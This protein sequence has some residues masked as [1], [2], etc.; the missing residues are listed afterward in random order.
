[1]VLTLPEK[2]TFVHSEFMFVVFVTNFMQ[3]VMYRY[4]FDLHAGNFAQIIY[5]V[6]SAHLMIYLSCPRWKKVRASSVRFSFFASCIFNIFS[7]YSCYFGSLVHNQPTFV[8]VI[9][10]LFNAFATWF[11]Y[12]ESIE[13]SD[14]YAAITKEMEKIQIEKEKEEFEKRKA[15]EEEFYAK[16]RKE[17]DEIV[18]AP[19]CQKGSDAE[20]AAKVIKMNHPDFIIE[21]VKYGLQVRLNYCS[22]RIRIYHQDNQVINITLG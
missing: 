18:K 9:N 4:V 22:N 20:L 13:V 15:E 2:S 17:F 6:T 16:V 7:S 3:F 1:M 11:C 14:D 19:E 8:F 12:L 21:M 5:V 10:A